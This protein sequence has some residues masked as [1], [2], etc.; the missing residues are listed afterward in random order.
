MADDLDWE[1]WDPSQTSFTT[2]MI[3]G[4][5]AGL[6]EHVS[7]FP[8]DTLKTQVQCE[9]CGSVSPMRT[10]NCATRIVERE[11]LFRLWRG[12]SAMFA[13]C[14]PAHAAYFSIFESMKKMTGADADGHRPVEAAL[15]GASAAFSHDMCMTP[16]DTIKQRMQ[17]G[18]Y[19]SLTHCIKSVAAKEG[20]AAFYVSLPTTLAMNLPFGMIMVAVNESSRK[21]LSNGDK[22]VSVSTSMIAGALAGGVAAAFTTPLDI[23]KTRLQTQNLEPCA[24]PS[25]ARG[26][27]SSALH[28]PMQLRPPV[29]SA[30][31]VAAQ[32]WREEGALGFARGLAPRVLQQ[33]PAVAVSWT[34]YETAKAF[35][36]ERGI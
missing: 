22:R 35:L 32:I 14:I 34:A 30:W 29:R 27:M 2:H 3:A 6:A 21:F 24:T 25:T 28:N 12:V 33:A 7:I 10:W 20:F 13:G 31:Q 23:I 5:L 36:T 15:C 18:Y 9:K 8:L 19:K 4:S 16:F 1:E 26:I 11:G 17:L